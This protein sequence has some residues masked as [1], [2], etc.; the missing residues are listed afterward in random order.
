MTRILCILLITFITTA[1]TPAP[2]KSNG[3]GGFISVFDNKLK[4]ADRYFNNFEYKSAIK[5]YTKLVDKGKGD[6][7]VK[8]RLA[9]S[10]LKVN[11]PVNAEKWYSEVIHSD[12]ITPEHQIQYAHTLLSNG[13]YEEARQ[14]IESYE[15]AESDYRSKAILN[16]LNKLDV[17]YADSMFYQLSSVKDNKPHYSDFS[18]TIFKDGIVF[19]S[20][21]HDKGPKFKWDDTPFLDLYYTESDVASARPFSEN[22][23]SKYHE[24]PIAFYDD[25]SKTIF[26]R[27]NYLDKELGLTDQGINN[28]QLYTASWDES[29]S[30]WDN[31]KPINF[32]IKDYSY[33]H[34]TISTDNGKLYFISDMPG[35]FGGTD[36]YVSE[37]TE[38][39]WSDPVNMGEVINT[40]GNE[41]YPFID[42]EDNLYFASNGHGGLGGLD[43]YQI[44]LNRAMDI[45]NMGYPLNTTADDFGFS[46]SPSGETAYISSNREGA[47]NIFQI[48]IKA[49]DL[50]MILADNSVNTEVPEIDDQIE[51]LAT[52]E[53][54]TSSGFDEFEDSELLSTINA[55][56]INEDNNILDNANLKLFVNGEE[57]ENLVSNEDG[58]VT[59]QVPAGQEY[60]LIA[61]KEGFEDRTITIPAESLGQEEDLL[62]VMNSIFV[63]SDISDDQI[64]TTELEPL[65]VAADPW[66]DS[67]LE[68]NDRPEL[69][70]VQLAEVPEF[71]EVNEDDLPTTELD[72]LAV[73][74]DGWDDSVS[75]NNE[76]PEI[77]GV[78]L[79]GLPDDTVQN[80]DDLPTTELDPLAVSDDGWDDS[81]SDNNERP[82]I[83]GVALTGLPDDTGQNEDDLPTTELDPLA[84]SDDGWDDSVSD[85][86]ERP[87]I[88]G[89]AL[90]G[91]P[92]DTG[93]NEDDLPT[94]ELDPLAVSDDGWDD[95]LLDNNER[96]EI[97][98]VAL[99]DLPDDSSQNSDDRPTTELD[100]LAVNRRWLG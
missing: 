97:Q 95:S 30:D 61:S 76:R 62:I 11:D 74:D 73:S 43:V 56:I 2:Q 57:T 35:G 28:L 10:Y 40:S 24:G 41:M 79:T 27:S 69:N 72:P 75:D 3:G 7:G 34:P 99:T 55:S 1:Y 45:R 68:Q 92:D 54:S 9:E 78:A 36:I 81:V 98:G 84:V 86:N 66:N 42:N 51:L 53:L 16:T 20:S 63:D 60:T 6:D 18:P 23:N 89:V 70:G 29:Q 48:D 25:Y 4:R 94:T 22:L 52:S 77:Q 71:S 49:P 67:V 37:R 46:L 85:N 13:K 38:S 26:T 19:V 47:D 58:K 93:Q 65:A 83:Q 64:P 5:L 100:P 82:E 12:Q 17:F 90:T 21:R 31:I 14:I 91:L 88:Q 87:E 15:F 32:I 33:G 44:Q 39:G 96:L 59:I 8:L 80:E 50:E